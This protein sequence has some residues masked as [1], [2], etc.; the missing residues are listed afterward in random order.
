VVLTFFSALTLLTYPFFAGVK[1]PGIA[2]PAVA[3]VNVAALVLARKHVGAFWKGKARVPVPGVG[4]YNDAIKGTMELRLNIL[5][6]AM[7]WMFTGVYAL[8]DFIR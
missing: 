6:L 2:T 3:L 7:S 1:L 4:D 8:V 5:Y